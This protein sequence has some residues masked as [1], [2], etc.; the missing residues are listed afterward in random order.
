MKLM[1][2]IELT[3]VFDQGGTIV[4][5][6]LY[7]KRFEET[8]GVCWRKLRLRKFRRQTYRVLSLKSECILFPNF[9]QF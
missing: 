8:C 4:L 9:P 6:R 5:I 2:E 7:G 1:T 3:H